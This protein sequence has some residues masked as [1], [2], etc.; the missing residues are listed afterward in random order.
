MLYATAA[1]LMNLI[2]PDSKS[3]IANY[4]ICSW[5]AILKKEWLIK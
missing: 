5:I 3:A 2:V 4:I 1:A